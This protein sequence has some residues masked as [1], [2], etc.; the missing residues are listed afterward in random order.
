MGLSFDIGPKVTKKSLVNIVI[1]AAPGSGLFL[2]RLSNHDST[3]PHKVESYFS[4]LH[5]L[6]LIGTIG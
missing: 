2:E 5:Y 3:V 1:I 4:D 6:I